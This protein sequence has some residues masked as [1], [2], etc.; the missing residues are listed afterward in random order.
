[1]TIK[2]P[3]PPRTITGSRRSCRAW[4]RLSSRRMAPE[5]RSHR[6]RAMAMPSQ[7][8]PQGHSVWRSVVV[9]FLLKSWV[10]WLGNPQQMEKIIHIP[11]GSMYG[12]YANIK[13]I[14]MVNVTVYSIHGS[15][16][17][18]PHH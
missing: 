6:G 12:I 13:I 7:R 17:I 2:N 18:Y 16:G 5:N 8:N 4:E 15:Y 10:Q 9:G 14:L 1:M 11:I 3:V